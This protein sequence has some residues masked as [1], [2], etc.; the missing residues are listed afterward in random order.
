[1]KIGL[2]DVDSHNFPNIPLMKLSSWHKQEWDKVEFARP[3]NQYDKIYISK[4]FTESREP[5]LEIDCKH[6]V[7]GGS[8]YGLNNRLPDEVEHIYPDYSLYPDLTKDT[9]YGMLTRGCPRYNHTFCITPKKDGRQSVKVA[10]LSEFWCG[11]KKVV[12]LDQNILA[13]KD[14]ID[15]LKQLRDSKAEIEFNGGMDARFLNNQIIEILKQIKVK[16]YHFAWDDPKENLVSKFQLFKDSGV[17]NTN[18]VGVYVLTNYWSTI[19]EDLM[20]IYTLRKMGYVPYVMVYDKQKFVNSKGRWLPGIE[21]KY[22]V[23]QLRHFKTCQ[24]MQRWTAY[25]AII[26]SCPQFEDYEYY[27]KWVQKGKPVPQ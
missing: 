25:R 6:I 3:G 16:D 10:D 9:A 11:Q 17:K 21:S 5:N 13:C 20:R 22:S 19:E 26:K 4:V 15:L 12:L 23:E 8:G 1:L 14:H 18:S 2:I 27:K 7:R 24:H